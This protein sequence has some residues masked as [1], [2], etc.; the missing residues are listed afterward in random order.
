[1]LKSTSKTETADTPYQKKPPKL[2]TAKP[3]CVRCSRATSFRF[4][5]PADSPLVSDLA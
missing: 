1:V 4:L 3:V 5:N 2:R